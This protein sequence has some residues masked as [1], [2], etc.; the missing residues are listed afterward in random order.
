MTAVVV[1]VGPVTV[2]GP[3]SVPAGRAE[4]AVAGLGD[5]LTVVD[6]RVI[7]MVH[8]LRDVMVAAAGGRARSLAVVVPSWWSARWTAIVA[9]AGGAVADE[10]RLY[11]RGPLLSAALDVA[12]AEVGVD[13]VAIAAPGRPVRVYGRDTAALP[14]SL[15]DS[16][17]IDVPPGVATPPDTTTDRCTRRDDVAAA[18]SATATRTPLRI[19][20]PAVVAAAAIAVTACMLPW[21]TRDPA[22]EQWRVLTEGGAAIEVPADWTA[23]RITSGPGSARVRISASAG[24]PALHLTQSVGPAALGDIAESLRRAIS[25]APAGVFVDLRTDG[26]VGDR[27]AVTYRE[28]RDGSQTQWAV[29]GDGQVRIAIG[30]QSAPGGADALATVCARAVRSARAVR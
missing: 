22:P 21:V 9:D 16:A 14:D 18:V 25:S 10:V 12:V 15:P 19:R 26:A 24:L 20:R 23:E 3:G 7:D 4:A 6:D 28:V 13:I 30:C 27:P 17:L 29:V 5:R 8:V 11:R 2:R 1:E